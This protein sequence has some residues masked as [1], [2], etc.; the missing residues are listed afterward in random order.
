MR[1]PVLGNLSPITRHALNPQ[2]V[3]RGVTE[4]LELSV[5]R[6][7]RHKRREVIEACLLLA[8]CENPTLRQILQDPLDSSFVA[9]I[10][11]LLHSERPGVMLL[12]LS[13][14]DDPHP[15][16]SVL[17][18]LGRRSGRNFVKRLL[19]KIGIEPAAAAAHNL[20]RIE[21]WRGS[22]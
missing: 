8:D 3:H 15:P 18:A 10:D 17:Q 21:T 6:F 20:K 2:L 19:K 13:F 16:S 7:V 22:V 5:R 1:E 9:M 4:S 11:A 12:V 14:L